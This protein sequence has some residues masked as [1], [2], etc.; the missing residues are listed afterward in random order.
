MPTLPPAQLSIAAIEEIA[1]RF[2]AEVAPVA[3]ADEA[4]VAAALQGAVAL[5][6]DGEI[7]G[8][9]GVSGATSEEDEQIAKAGA[10]AL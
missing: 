2:A 10:A 6:Q 9:V 5:I 1:K 7:V 3:A 8:A 4:G